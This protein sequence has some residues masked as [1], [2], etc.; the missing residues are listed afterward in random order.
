MSLFQE[1]VSLV[2]VRKVG[3]S[4]DH[5]FYLCSKC[6]Q[7]GCRCSTSSATCFLFDSSPV[8]FRSFAREEE[9][10]F[11]CQFRVCFRPYSFLCILF[12]NDLLQLFCT[13]CIQ[14]GYFREYNERVSRITTQILDC[15]YVCVAAERS[16]VCSAVS[17]IAAAVC[18]ACTFTHYGFTDNQRRAFFFSLCFFDCRTDFVRIITVDTKYV[19]SPC[20]I[21]HGSVFNGYVFRF[22]RKLNIVGVIEHNQVV[23]SQCTGNTSRTLRDF[24]LNTTVRDVSVNG[25]IHHLVE[26]GFQEFGS[27]SSTYCKSVSLSQWTRSIFDATHDVHFRVSRSRASPLTEFFQLVQREFSCQCQRR[28]KHRRHVARVE[29]EAVTSFPTGIF[30][31]VY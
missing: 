17:F 12:S 28:I 5:V 29:E 24:F 10:Q 8:H 22:C 4:N 14:F 26:T 21:F 2:R 27:D 11:C 30:R 25:L 9:F 1:T 3:R 19:P 13:F 20:F 15:I 31:I 23:Q 6:A 16:T 7:Y 18:L